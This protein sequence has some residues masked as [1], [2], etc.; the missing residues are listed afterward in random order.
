LRSFLLI[1]LG[2]LRILSGEIWK[3][4]F[5]LKKLVSGR[6]LALYF[7]FIM[8]T[9][10]EAVINPTLLKLI[11]ESFET[12]SVN[13]LWFSLVFGI[14]GNLLLV[15]GLGGKRYFYSKL[16]AEFTKRFKTRLFE[17]HLRSEDLPE[18]EVLSNIENDSTQ[19]ENLYVEPTVIILSSLGF[20]T[21]SIIYALSTNFWLG[22]LFIIF[23]SIPALCSGIGAKKLENIS[24]RRSAVNQTYLAGLTNILAGVSI[25]RN[26]GG[27]KLFSDKYRSELGASIDQSLTYEKQRTKNTILINAIDAICSVTPIIIGA[28]MTFSGRLDG[29]SFIAIYLVSN[30]IGYQFQDLAYFMNTRKSSLSLVEKYEPLLESESTDSQTDLSPIFPIELNDV[31]FSVNGKA[32]ISN[33]SFEIGDG[34]KV[35]IIGESGAGK[36]TL[37][38]LIHGDLTPTSGQISYHH[39]QLDHKQIAINSAYIQQSSHIFVGMSLVDNIVLGAPLDEAKLNRIIR[40]VKLCDFTAETLIDDQMSGGEKQRVEIARSLYHN[41]PLILAD[42]VKANLDRATAQEIEDVLFDVKQTVI[43]VIHHYTPATLG[44]Y[45]KV[46]TLQ[47][48][49]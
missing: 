13:L 23:Y 22:L 32:L 48:N 45:D 19:L 5:M 14:I 17:R 4:F 1:E 37:L 42:E 28:F 12:T 24:E 20:T 33:F 36:T 39:K 29:A 6:T 9:W 46:I 31:S 43:E 2:F 34:D 49:N 15:I 40:S 38:R 16:I 10:L 27:Q 21:V 7:L 18:D 35:A 8:I 44:R 26:Y 47:K 30:N 11:I 25:I 41:R 3:G